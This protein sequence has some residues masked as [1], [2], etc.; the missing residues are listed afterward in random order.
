MKNK[1]RCSFTFLLLCVLTL[2]V[3]FMAVEALRGIRQSN[4]IEDLIT[5]G[6]VSREGLAKLAE[7]HYRY[8]HTYGYTDQFT[9]L[10][11]AIEH[12]EL[13][14]LGDNFVAVILGEKSVHSFFHPYL[15]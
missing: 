9:L 10:W 14:T 13:E 4:M 12:I 8:G 2:L 15:E 6:L 7:I 3:V 11:D 1:T 5:K